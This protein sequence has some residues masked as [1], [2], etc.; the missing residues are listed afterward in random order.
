[1]L[2]RLSCTLTRSCN[3]EMSCMC[4]STT[5]VWSL[6]LCSHQQRVRWCASQTANA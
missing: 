6:L 1:M 5:D 3:S 4:P 2:T